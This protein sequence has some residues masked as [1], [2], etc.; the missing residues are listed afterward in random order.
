MRMILENK[1][2]YFDEALFFHHQITNKRLTWKYY[3][4]LRESFGIANSFLIS[5]HYAKNVYSNRTVIL[6]YIIRIIK[7]IKMCWKIKYLLF[8]AKYENSICADYHQNIG[9][10][11]GAISNLTKIKKNIQTAKNNLKLAES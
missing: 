1:T 4:E 6:Y 2:I 11:K 7:T 3:I 8:P 5:Y 10:I 9:F